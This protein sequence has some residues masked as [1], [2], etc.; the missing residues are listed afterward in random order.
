MI[1]VKK[2]RGFVCTTAHPVGCAQNVKNQINYVKENGTFESAKKVLVLGCSAGYGLASR[3]SL[4]FGSNAMTLGVSFEKEPTIKR[5]ATAGW[6][7]N[8]AFDIEAEKAG[9]YSK[10]IN[11]DAFSL[12]TKQQIAYIIK[13]DMGKID[14]LVYSLASPRRTNH[15]GESFKSV[16]KP[17]G[18][19]FANKSINLDTNEVIS[20]SFDSAEGTEVDDTVKVMGGED[21]ALWVDFLRENNLVDSNFTTMAYSYLGPEIT[22]PIYLNGTIGMAKNHLKQTADNLA[23]GLKDIDGTAFVAVNK[24]LVTQASSA[25][26]VVP[27][28]ISILY[29][30]MKEKGLHE[31][32]IEQMYRFFKTYSDGTVVIDNNG[33]IRMDDYE[34]RVDVQSEVMESWNK[35]DSE[36]MLSLTDIAGFH[37]DFDN[38][39]GFEIDGVDYSVD[40]STIL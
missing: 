2:K 24:A 28:Y 1:I 33:Y 17:I 31:H 4:A 39:F 3:I 14:M 37:K 16:I 34:M 25:I 30:V 12:A 11:A 20:A 27:L 10:T 29:K 6:Y 21:W 19:P 15:E 23:E 22:H 36:N 26:P 5:T 13:N 8:R 38:I 40:V 35:I 7:N 18:E 32:C 9:I